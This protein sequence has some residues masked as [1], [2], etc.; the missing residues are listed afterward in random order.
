MRNIMPYLT[1]LLDDVEESARWS[2]GAT[3]MMY[4]DAAGDELGVKTFIEHV[5]HSKE[6]T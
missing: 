6:T 3:K 5:L 4:T 2:G 1:W